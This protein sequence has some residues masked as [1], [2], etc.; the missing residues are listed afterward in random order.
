MRKFTT[1]YGQVTLEPAK[2]TD[3]SGERFEGAAI[4]F[5]DGTWAI[6]NNTTLD[7]VNRTPEKEIISQLESLYTR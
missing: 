3:L 2:G 6:K 4:G 5:P 1:K 7:A